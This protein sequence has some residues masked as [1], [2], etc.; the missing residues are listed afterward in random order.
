MADGFIP[1]NEPLLDGNELAY[2]TDAIES[3]W[4]SSEGSYVTAFEEAFSARCGRAFGIAVT[5]GTVALD[6]AVEALGLGEGDEVILPTFTII[7]CLA[8]LLRRRIT[9]VFV[10]ADPLTWTMDVDALEGVVT[11]RTRAIM[12][13]HIYGLPVDMDPVMEFAG[14]Y[15]LGVIEDAAEAHGSR[16]RGRPCG[17]FGEVSCFSFYANKH[18][19]TGEGGMLVTDDAALV[20]R[21]RSL[22]NLCFI[23]DKRFVHEDLGYNARMTNVQA[24]LGLAQVESLDAHLQRKRALGARYLK[25]LSGVQGVSFAPAATDYAENDYWVFGMVLDDDIP[26]DAARFAELLAERG[27]GTRPFFHPLHLQPVLT[28]FGVEV[29]DPFPVAE[30]IARRGLYLPSGVGTS[31]ERIDRVIAA[32]REVMASLR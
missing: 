21:L 24:A 5:N 13:V 14:R 3:G 2:V 27:V 29:H 26:I 10:D 11:E 8:P 28:E 30:R 32:L 15:G 25:G 4:V 31:D 18:V 20:K 19:T 7:S 22:R 12:P 16:Y 9:P 1:V 23:A 6:L 17:S